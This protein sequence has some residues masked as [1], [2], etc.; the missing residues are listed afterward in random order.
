MLAAF[1]Q[2]QQVSVAAA[3]ELESE[4]LNVIAQVV[5]YRELMLRQRINGAAA[6]MLSH[7]VSSDLDNLAG[8]LNTER[9][10][11]TPETATTDAVTESDTALRCGLRLRLKG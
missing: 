2:E 9:L 7:A 6:C 10:I 3:L 4:P 1:P 11:I 5:A 8:N